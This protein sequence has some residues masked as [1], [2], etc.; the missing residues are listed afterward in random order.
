MWLTIQ[1]HWWSWIVYRSSTSSKKTQVF[2]QNC[3]C[4]TTCSDTHNSNRTWM[5]YLRMVLSWLLLKW[6]NTEFFILKRP[7]RQQ[8]KQVRFTWLWKAVVHS[9]LI[10]VFD[11]SGFQIAYGEVSRVHLAFWLL[12]WPLQNG[13]FSISLQPTCW[14]C[15]QTRH[16]RPLHELPAHLYKMQSR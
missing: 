4:R 9:E 7:T 2:I 15:P 12:K 14:A 10:F 13:K 5:L 3:H 1:G 8:E 16:N 11:L 6:R